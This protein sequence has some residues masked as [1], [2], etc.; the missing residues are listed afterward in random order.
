[1]WYADVQNVIHTQNMAWNKEIMKGGRK[2]E[3]GS[4]ENKPWGR[5]LVRCFSPDTR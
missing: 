2:R 5:A 4:G 1:M 3:K